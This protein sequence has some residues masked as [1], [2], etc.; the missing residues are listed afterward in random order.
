MKSNWRSRVEEPAERFART[1]AFVSPVPQ[2]LTDEEILAALR[3]IPEAYQD[4]ILLSDVEELTYKEIAA[5]LALPL[6]TVMSR[7]HR[8]RDMLRQQLESLH[9]GYLARVVSE[10]ADGESK[11]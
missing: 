4:I 3:G 6:G 1:L 11:T 10:R 9:A 2:E 5:A 8:G 7:L